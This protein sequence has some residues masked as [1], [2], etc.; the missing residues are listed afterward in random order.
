MPTHIACVTGAAARVG[1]AVALELATHGFDLIIH[2]NKNKEGAYQT[3]KE[4]ESLGRQA[5]CIQANLSI[6]DECL[7]LIDEI[8]NTYDHLELLVNNAS[9]FSPQAFDQITHLMW[10]EMMQVNVTAPFTLSQ[11]LL[12]L[13]R[14]GQL[15]HDVIELEQTCWRRSSIVHL[16]DIGADRPLKGYT[17]YAVSKAALQM[18]VKSMAIELAP[19]INCIGI[20][21]GQVAWPPFFDENSR[22]A[23]EKR[24][25]MHRSGTPKDIATL[26]RHLV[27]EAPYINGAIIP[28]DGG[29]ACRY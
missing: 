28:V 27:L 19:T 20:S 1:R 8:K 22:M 13:L 5:I 29:L 21:P 2:Y 12:P 23:I 11:G 18:L 10:Q 26:V 6:H 17:H 4:I 3:Q 14:Q 25:P 7:A 16:C 9:L 15:A 24:I